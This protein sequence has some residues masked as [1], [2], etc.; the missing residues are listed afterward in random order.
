[1]FT[2]ITAYAPAMERDMAKVRQALTEQAER[3]VEVT[4]GRI[5]SIGSIE[6]HEVARIGRRWTAVVEHSALNPEYSR[7]G[8]SEA[9]DANDSD[10]VVACDE[11][12]AKAGIEYREGEHAQGDHADF[13]DVDC[14]ACQREM[15]D[16]GIEVGQ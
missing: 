8:I 1:M 3:L 10:H 15:R 14:P 2:E 9:H 12:W 4:G 16:L 5:V 11:C 7:E 6:A 13:M